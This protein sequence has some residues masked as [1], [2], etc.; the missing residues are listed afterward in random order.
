[1]ET[2]FGVSVPPPSGTPFPLPA[3]RGS[4]KMVSAVLSASRV[5]GLLGRALPRVGR[6]MS[7]GAHGEEGSGTGARV[8]VGASVAGTGPGGAVTLAGG[9]AGGSGR[10]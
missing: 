2:S 5:S 8:G 6:P 9:L 1:M 3:R 10:G 7:R 4:S